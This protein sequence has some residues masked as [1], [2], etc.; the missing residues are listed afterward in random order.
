MMNPGYNSNLP[1]LLAWAGMLSG[2]SSDVPPAFFFKYQCPQCWS[3]TGRKKKPCF[4]PDFTLKL[5]ALLKS[6]YM[7]RNIYLY[8]I[9]ATLPAALCSLKEGVRCVLAFSD[10]HFSFFIFL[11][12]VS[13]VPPN[14][15][16]SC[17][18]WDA[19]MER[20]TRSL[21]HKGGG[22]GGGGSMGRAVP[23]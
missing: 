18:V 19:R 20:E 11:S 13:N 6:K 2:C 3:R 21:R 4:Q 16:F 7:P 8:F 1:S 12:F 14:F 9:L 23:K 22:G 5:C 15:F 17:R 10:P